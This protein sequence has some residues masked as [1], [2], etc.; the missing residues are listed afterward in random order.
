MSLARDLYLRCVD[1]RSAVCA[2]VGLPGASSPLL[3]ES[4][5]IQ[6]P[7]PRPCGR[8]ISEGLRAQP[9][10]GAGAQFLYFSADRFGAVTGRDGA[11]AETGTCASQ[12]PQSIRRAGAGL[13]L[14]RSAG[15]FRCRSQSCETDS[16]LTSGP[17]LPTPTFIWV[18]SRR[19]W[20][21]AAPSM[22]RSGYRRW[23]LWAASRR[24][25]NNR[26]NWRKPARKLLVPWS[27]MWRAYLEGDRGKSLEALDQALG[28]VPIHTADPECSFSCSVPAGE[29]ERDRTRAGVAVRRSRPGIPL[30]LCSLVPSLAGFVALSS[31][32]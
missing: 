22:G 25:S 32:V 17:V 9:G 10:P 7:Q 4:C 2:G 5:G 27:A 30:P 31:P 18:T 21:T 16:T 19:C 8:G 11:P 3:R 24:R 26:E 23:R 20:S 13:P 6:R 12:R 15:G 28:S 29:I 14:L 1:A